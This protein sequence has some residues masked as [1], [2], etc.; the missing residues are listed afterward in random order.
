MQTTNLVSQLTCD[1]MSDSIKRSN[2]GFDT[3]NRSPH[4]LR[5]NRR[6]APVYP[7]VHR[8]TSVSLRAIRYFLV[9]YLLAMLVAKGVME[10]GT[11]K[12]TVSTLRF[13]DLPKNKRLKLKFRK[14]NTGLNCRNFADVEDP[15]FS[16]YN[17][18]HCAHA[19]YEAREVPLSPLVLSASAGKSDTDRIHRVSI[20]SKTFQTDAD[21]K[22]YYWRFWGLHTNNIIPSRYYIDVHDKLRLV[23][24]EYNALYYSKDIVLPMTTAP[25]Y[26]TAHLL[27]IFRDGSTVAQISLSGFP[28]ESFGAINPEVVYNIAASVASRITHP[29]PPATALR[30]LAKGALHWGMGW[31]DSLLA[32]CRAQAA[33]LHRMVGSALAAAR[34]PAPFTSSSAPPITDASPPLDDIDAVDDYVEEDDYHQ[35]AAYDD[36]ITDPPASGAAEDATPVSADKSATWPGMA[37]SLADVSLDANYSTNNGSDTNHSA[38]SPAGDQRTD[39]NAARTHQQ[40]TK[41]VWQDQSTTTATHATAAPTTKAYRAGTVYFG[42]DSDDATNAMLSMDLHG[43]SCTD[44]PLPTVHRWWWLRLLPL[45][46]VGIAAEAPTAHADMCSPR[47]FPAGRDNLVAALGMICVVL[48]LLGFGEL[49]DPLS[50]PSTRAPASARAPLSLQS[51]YRAAAPATPVHSSPLVA[52]P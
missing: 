26:Q 16:R 39:H 37:G 8:C 45:P 30:S 4:V 7:R 47:T 38:H 32:A 21:A 48:V 11:G 42:F 20:V 35:T 10:S 18:E 13:Q 6:R 5:R 22:E 43:R 17:G 49:V 31:D 51:T 28:H 14:R 24:D 44:S 3:P 19:M 52:R 34:T 29:A 15:Y 50:Q 33:G 9:C 25:E 1:I 40:P 41:H 2:R 27:Y 23:G 36:T 12:F 46:G